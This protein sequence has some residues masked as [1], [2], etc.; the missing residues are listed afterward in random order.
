MSN[1]CV[2][3]LLL[4]S[5]LVCTEG[6]N[7]RIK[8]EADEECDV[9]Y[10]TIVS[11]YEHT[12]CLP[13]N[14]FAERMPLTQ[15]IK[16]EIVNKHNAIRA[17]MHAADMLKMNWDDALAG[18]AEKWAMQCNGSHDKN[19][20]EPDKDGFVGQ[21]IAVAFGTG[22]EKFT[23][24]DAVD[25]WA[26]EK[27]DWKFGEWTKKTGHFIMEITANSRTVGCG[28]ATCTNP[29]TGKI[30]RYVV[31]NYHPS[32]GIGNPFQKGKA[33][34]TCPNKCKDELCD[35]EKTL[36]CRRGKLRDCKCE[37][38]PGFKSEDCS[39][40]MCRDNYSWCPLISREKFCH[41][42]AY[43]DHCTKHC[44]QCEPDK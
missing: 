15:T 6:R 20:F 8:R 38:F 7:T 34:Q 3:L 10:E 43:R 19:R 31:C 16:G 21:N 25:L 37:C 5:L 26:N 42:R 28:G 44:T 18:T 23:F 33:C 1:P 40:P 32:V 27:K 9:I 39:Q 36:V 11:D 29:E 35:C 12:R 2:V 4:L 17:K 14:P 30:A 41:R 13:D 22:A 24:E